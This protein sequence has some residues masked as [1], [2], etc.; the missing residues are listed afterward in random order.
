MQNES[1]LCIS[2]SYFCL[3]GSVFMDVCECMYIYLSISMSVLWFPISHLPKLERVEFDGIS[4]IGR[5]IATEPGVV[6]HGDGRLPHLLEGD[7]L[8][9]GQ[10]YPRR[11]GLELGCGRRGHCGRCGLWTLG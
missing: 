5:G 9:P 11:V 4:P 7:G 2:I 3:S 10:R 1:I 8:G 6:P